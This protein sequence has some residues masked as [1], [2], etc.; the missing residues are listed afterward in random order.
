MDQLR[1]RIGTQKS[2]NLPNPFELEDVFQV[3]GLKFPYDA[4][5]SEQPQ[6]MLWSLATA[7]VCSFRCAILEST[8]F[9]QWERGDEKEAAAL[10]KA[11]GEDVLKK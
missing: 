7:T 5:F 4:L 9:E 6:S 8:Y 3:R 2:S 11:A 10:M 1:H